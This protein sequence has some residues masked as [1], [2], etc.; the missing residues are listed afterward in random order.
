MASRSAPLN[1]PPLQGGARI[2]AAAP[3]YEAVA[4]ELAI[5]NSGFIISVDP[6]VKFI[7]RHC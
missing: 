4:G 3:Y 5:I 7:I 2:I 1:T 6:G